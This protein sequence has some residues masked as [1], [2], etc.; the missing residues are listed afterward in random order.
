MS[1]SAEDQ[2][3][4]GMSLV[5]EGKL[6][7]AL[8]HLREAEAGLP[9]DYDLLLGIGKALAGTGERNPAVGY[10]RRCMEMNPDRPEAYLEWAAVCRKQGR[11]E[12]AQKLELMGTARGGASPRTEEDAAVNW[13]PEATAPRAGDVAFRCPGCERPILQGDQSGVC[14]DCRLNLQPI[15]HGHILPKWL[16]NGQQEFRCARCNAWLNGKEYVCPECETNLM[17]GESAELRPSGN[18]GQFLKSPAGVTALL[19]GFVLLCF[20]IGQFSVPGNRRE[21]GQVWNMAVQRVTQG[22]SEGVRILTD[23]SKG[24]KDARQLPD[25]DMLWLFTKYFGF[26]VAGGIILILG[27]M[28]Y[29]FERIS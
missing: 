24:P 1:F 28:K 10:F 12:Q 11:K 5:E 14:P 2:Y 22:T 21:A 17:T 6:S 4:I 16:L 18:R 25:S 15:R 26:I 27:W 3:R 19:L 8:Y 29:Y 9:P 7:E 13:N 23:T 20:G